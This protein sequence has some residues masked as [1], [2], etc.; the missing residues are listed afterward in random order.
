MINR[1]IIACLP[2]PAHKYEGAYPLGFEK[3]IPKMIQ[4][5]DYIH[6]FCGLA[7]TGHRVDN[8]KEVNPDTLADCQTCGH[9]GSKHAF[10][11]YPIDKNSPEA[12]WKSC[13]ECF[14]NQTKRLKKEKVIQSK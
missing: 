9:H 11:I 8:K 4:T 13:M 14:D 1:Q 12:C 5:K 3:Y 6:L 2:R 10:D 7:K